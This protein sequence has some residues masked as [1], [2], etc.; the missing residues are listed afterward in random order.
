M[1]AMAGCVQFASASIIEVPG[2][3]STIQAAV[4]AA[5]TG[6]EIHVAA[7]IWRETINLRGKAIVL[8]GA[9]GPQSTTLDGRGL[10]GSV[11]RCI[12]GEA[13]ETRIEGF[14][15]TGGSGDVG[16]HGPEATVGGGLLVRSSSPTIVNCVF[17]ENRASLHGGAVYCGD[18]AAATFS[19]CMFESNV[20]E[21]G[22]AVFNIRSSPSFDSCVFTGNLA[23]YGGGAIY[24]DRK[25][26][27]DF[28]DC[29]FQANEAIYNGGA[30][31]DYESRGTLTSCSFVRNA[32]AFKGGAIY[33]AY[34]SN[35]IMH[36]CVFVTQAD[37][38]A[39]RR[40]VQMASKDQTGACC[41]GGG[42]IIASKS[43]CEDAG[44]EFSGR[45]TRCSI[46]EQTCSRRMKG[47]LN[48]DGTVDRTDM[49]VLMLIWR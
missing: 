7:G 8:L 11:L 18:G 2:D 22:G 34:R 37:D 44:G 5:Q 28:T 15:I 49:A 20:A 39:G 35:P 23:G 6:D 33:I 9:A 30:V 40:G 14:T 12:E 16:A 32:A 27:A 24:N 41:V 25:C 46:E 26:A 3:A 21:K 47:D 45:G 17:R 13:A 10:E 43:A 29:R 31:Y 48:H 4:D 42:C 38:V 1:L 36:D 19:D